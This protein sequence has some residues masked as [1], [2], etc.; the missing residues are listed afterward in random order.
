[1]GEKPMYR[2]DIVKNDPGKVAKAIILADLTYTIVV[3]VV[4]VL[5]LLGWAI[6]LAWK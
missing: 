2:R 6:Y 5:A 3:I 1:M 4:G